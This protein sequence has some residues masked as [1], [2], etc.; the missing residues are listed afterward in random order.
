[1]LSLW[2]KCIKQCANH[3]NNLENK[4][5]FTMHSVQTFFSFFEWNSF[6]VY[7]LVILRSQ[8]FTANSFE[9]ILFCYPFACLVAKFQ[10]FLFRKISQNKQKAMTTILIIEGN[11]E[12]LAVAYFLPANTIIRVWIKREHNEIEWESLWRWACWILCFW[13]F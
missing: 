8:N 12:N 5:V 9:D 3:D 13:S 10:S 4:F 1:M 2:L 11:S 6:V 7:F